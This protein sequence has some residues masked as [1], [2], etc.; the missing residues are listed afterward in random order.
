MKKEI[1]RHSV[2]RAQKV[3]ERAPDA[4]QSVEIAVVKFHVKL[5]ENS[6]NKTDYQLVLFLVTFINMHEQ[7]NWRKNLNLTIEKTMQ[8]SC[9][10]PPLTQCEML[11][12]I[13]FSP[14][15]QALHR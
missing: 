9:I 13:P 1:V 5:T 14:S 7:A 10:N 3:R 4:E 12:K 8:P 11:S 15:R 2:A 6:L